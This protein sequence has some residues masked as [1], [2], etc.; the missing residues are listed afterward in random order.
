MVN[1]TSLLSF[2]W[3]GEGVNEVG[4]NKATGD[5]L[6]KV[7][8]RFYRPT[9]VVSCTTVLVRC[10]WCVFMNFNVFLPN[11]TPK[12]NQTVH[13]VSHRANFHS[14]VYREPVSHLI[15]ADHKKQIWAASWQNQQNGMKL[16]AQ[17]RLRP[18]WASAQSDQSLRNPHEESLVP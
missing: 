4:K 18:A 2:R 9:E 11:R 15:I 8:P 6:V 13:P 5:V 1:F 10:A 12:I 14:F 7:N 17:R 3:E 16:C